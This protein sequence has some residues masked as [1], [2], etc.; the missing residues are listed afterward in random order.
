M[1]NNPLYEA[2]EEAKKIK[3]LYEVNTGYSLFAKLERFFGVAMLIAVLGLIAILWRPEWALWSQ[4]A[5]L[6]LIGLWLPNSYLSEKFEDISAYRDAAL[7]LLLH[8]V[9]SNPVAT[10]IVYALLLGLAWVVT[11]GELNAPAFVVALVYTGFRCLL[12][13]AAILIG[14][15]DVADWLRLHIN[16]MNALPL[17]GMA[18]GWFIG[19]LFRND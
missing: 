18:I 10:L 6:T 14:Y 19:S 16:F 9:L 11:R 13:A 12:D 7:L 2:A 17:L 1:Y 5:A 4:L 8:G 3:V 15:W